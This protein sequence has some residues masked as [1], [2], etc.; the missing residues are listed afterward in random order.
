MVNDFSIERELEH[1]IIVKKGL[2]LVVSLTEFI[3][4]I[5]EFDKK[6]KFATL[7]VSLINNNSGPII[8]K[9]GGVGN[10]GESAYQDCIN[11]FN[12]NRAF[13]AE[14]NKILLC[15]QEI[16]TLEF[17]DLQDFP[18]TKMVNF[19]RRKGGNKNKLTAYFRQE[20]DH[21]LFTFDGTEECYQAASQKEMINFILLHNRFESTPEQTSI[22]RRG[23]LFYPT[24]K[25]FLR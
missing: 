13:H 12:R 3:K 11:N 5:D 19:V 17:S 8:S 25:E 18:L 9:I 1:K 4:D 7:N 14:E 2:I 22:R 10:T 16:P 21:I 20:K 23:R 15:C 24:I 6:E